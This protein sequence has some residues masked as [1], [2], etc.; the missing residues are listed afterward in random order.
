[1]KKFLLFI[2]VVASSMAVNAQ[3]EV[4]KL[5]FMPKVGVNLSTLAGEDQYYVNDKLES[6]N[7]IGVVA[8]IEGEYQMSKPLSLTVGVLYSLQGNKYDD[9]TYRKDY[10]STFHGVNVPVM[11][12]FY[13][14]KGLAVKAGLQ[15]GYAFYKYRIIRRIRKYYPLRP[16]S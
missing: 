12:N 4:G 13:I 6:K 5:S 2:A 7:R 15:A 1:M 3:N 9:V 10:T 16:Y 8:G 11:L 14:V